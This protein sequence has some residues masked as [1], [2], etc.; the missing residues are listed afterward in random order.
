MSTLPTRGPRWIKRYFEIKG[1][2]ERGVLFL[3]SPNLSNYILL[4][5]SRIHEPF[6]SRISASRPS[7]CLLLSLSPPLRAK[8]PDKMPLVEISG[9]PVSWKFSGTSRPDVRV[10]SSIGPSH[11]QHR[12]SRH[13]PRKSRSFHLYVYIYIYSAPGSNPLAFT[14]VHSS[15]LP[16]H[17]LS[18]TTTPRKKRST[19]ELLNSGDKI[20]RI[21]GTIY[22]YFHR[23]NPP[24]CQT[25]LDRFFSLI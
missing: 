15:S 20:H 2:T 10:S 24:L 11:R 21:T 12:C 6:V 22:I 1:T 19:P 23:I 9:E 4:A 3:P 25:I 8:Y 7:S 14:F 13:A 5:L 18:I 16:F 17:D